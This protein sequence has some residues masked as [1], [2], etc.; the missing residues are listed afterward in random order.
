M[1]TAPKRRGRPPGSGPKRTHTA[2]VN[3]PCTPEQAERYASAAAELGVPLAEWVREA[4]EAFAADDPA[5][6]AHRLRRA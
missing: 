2:R 4:C 5:V 1:T 3:V 6:H